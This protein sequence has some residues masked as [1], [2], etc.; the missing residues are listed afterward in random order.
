MKK[1]VGIFIFFFFCQVAGVSG[2]LT[3]EDCYRMAKENYP[4]IKRYGLIEQAKAYDLANANKGYL[5]QFS[6]SAKASY[7]S[8]VT[9]VPIS[10]PGMDIEGPDKDQYQT[11]LEL[12]QTIWDGGVIRSQKRITEAGSQADKQKLEVDL[13]ALNGRVNQLFFGILLLDGQ[14]KQNALLQ[15]DLKRNYEQVAAYVANG[16]A[17]Q[18]D[19]DAVKVNQLDALQ[20]ETELKAT[21]RA[22]REMLAALIGEKTGAGLAL[23]APE[24]PLTVGTAEIR[25]PELQLFEAQANV[26]ETQKKMLLSGN[27]PRLG[28]FAQ[29]GYS[30]PGLN[31]LKND[32]SAYYVAGVR[33]SWNFGGFY[34]KKNERRL[35]ENS[36]AD[37]NVQKEIFLF[38]TGLEVVQEN[39]EL[40]KIRDLMRDD[41]EIVTLRGSI[42]KAAEVKVA[43][44]TLSVTELLR[45]VNAEDV[46]RQNKVVHE[47]QFL[48]T[49]YDLKNTVN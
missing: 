31:M 47:I 6:L 7:Q 44:G 43:N 28:M 3:V 16:V 24:V 25:R 13:Y 33:L 21:A 34:T 41:D 14:L 4:L 49:F 9:E 22:Y 39:H 36:Q 5:P 38:N 30:N 40:Q 26:L 46:A 29:G 23:R 20:R 45:E 37:L 8:E 18:A 10:L 11:L 12:N 2:Q 27:L 32:F 35:L 17:N 15:S 48:K 42:R 1:T 19:L